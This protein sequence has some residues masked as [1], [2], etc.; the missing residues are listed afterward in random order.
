MRETSTVNSMLSTVALGTVTFQREKVTW[1]VPVAAAVATSLMVAAFIATGLA[2]KTIPLALGAL[3]MPLAG[4]FEPPGRRLLTQLWTLVWIMLT[5]LLGGLLSGNSTVV[6]GMGT[7]VSAVVA[8]GCGFAGGA[9]VNARVGGVLSLVLFAVFLGIPS[10]ERSAV[11]DCLLVGLGGVLVLGWLIALR[12]LLHRRKSWGAPPLSPSVIDRLR[13]RLNPR[14][15]FFR[16]G[17]RLAGAFTTATVISQLLMWPH[18]Y[19]IPM[20]VAW[21][22]LPDP[23]GTATRVAG[24]VLGTLLGVALITLVIEG[25]GP[26]PYAIAVLVG[27][28]ALIAEVFI[29]ANYLVCVVGVTSFMIA[30]FTLVGDPVGQTV[31]YRAIC[32]ILAGVI[33]IAWSMVWPSVGHEHR[34]LFRGRR[35]SGAEGGSQ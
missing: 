12:L 25:A 34:R 14:D 11:E 10:S 6:M 2:D 20:T 21:V 33:T 22:A 13:P 27:I 7:V 31:A 32:T 29:V 4:L 15:D 18:Q 30:L 24:R 5:T 3:F 19:W 23:T 8:F 16:H 35:E 28:G 26:G 1:R 9:G 17:V